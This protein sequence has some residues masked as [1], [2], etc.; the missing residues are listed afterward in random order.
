MY[1]PCLKPAA[2]LK[3][4]QF[5]RLKLCHRKV[6]KRV[7]VTDFRQTMCIVLLRVMLRWLM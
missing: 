6:L 1:S 3:K 2:P 4:T 5:Q 7:Q